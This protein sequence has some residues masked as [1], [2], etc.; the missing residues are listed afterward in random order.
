ML[1]LVN[2]LCASNT[3]EMLTQ[4]LPQRHE[5]RPGLSVSRLGF[6]GELDV[7]EI[8]QAH[9]KQNRDIQLQ[10]WLYSRYSLKAEHS[11]WADHDTQCMVDRQTKS[12]S[13]NHL[14]LEDTH[15]HRYPRLPMFWH[16]MLGF[17]QWV[18]LHWRLGWMDPRHEPIAGAAKR[19]GTTN[20]G[21]P[22]EKS[23]SD[24]YKQ[25]WLKKMFY[26]S[27]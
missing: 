4:K 9:W 12:H 11:W 23:S 2:S 26:K 14:L 6:V 13:K 5:F 27:V 3:K 15:I 18:T 19:S 16:T 21:A 22:S 7:Q 20:Q 17:V 10:R 8:V 1:G 24:K 25:R